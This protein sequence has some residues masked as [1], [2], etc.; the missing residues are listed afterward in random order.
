VLADPGLLDPGFLAR[1]E[2]LV[3][4][5]RRA[6][7]PR[8]R[9]KRRFLARGRGVEVSSYREYAPGDDVRFLD[10][11]AYARLERLYVRLVEDVIEPR[12]EL[13]V[14]TS[15][16]LGPGEP[17]PLGRA[18]RAAA[19]IAAISLARG[20][21]V[22][23]WALAQR[24]G[25]GVVASSPPIRG[26][27]RLVAL[28]RFLA[29]LEPAGSTALER[30]AV[31]VARATRSRGGAILFSDL[32]DPED[33][34]AALGRLSRE[35]FEALAIGVAP[36]DEAEAGACRAALRAGAALLVD[37][38][39]GTRRSAPFASESLAEAR[40]VRARL[41]LDAARRLAVRAVPR[42]PLPWDRPVEEVA[43]ALLGSSRAM[44]ALSAKLAP[45][46]APLLR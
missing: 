16:S 35:G 8:P 28:L 23:A 5:A 12:L 42:M 31:Q 32:L 10:W 40:R 29:R 43:L 30:G 21:T 33:A 38:E 46:T 36:R 14:D 44:A 18:T 1:L 9:R 13:L 3:R 26:P 24:T 41:D 22:R 17:R 19:A 25:A 20:V 37:A 7:P 34:A 11:A 4:L 6:P 27:G 2:R 15:G 45:E 39:T